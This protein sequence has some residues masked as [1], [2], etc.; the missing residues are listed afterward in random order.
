MHCHLQYAL[1]ALSSWGLQCLQDHQSYYA[2]EQRN[3][4]PTGNWNYRPWYWYPHSD[5][6][7]KLQWA[8]EKPRI[9]VSNCLHPPCGQNRPIQWLGHGP[10]L[11]LQQHLREISWRV[12]ED[13]LPGDEILRRNYQTSSGLFAQERKGCWE[14]RAQVWIRLS[15]VCQEW[16]IMMGGI[17]RVLIL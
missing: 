1:R 10:Y 15:D 11:R 5:F 12:A 8:H 16:C 6:G 4:G 3:S 7:H 17:M 13:S 14:R 9:N 2:E